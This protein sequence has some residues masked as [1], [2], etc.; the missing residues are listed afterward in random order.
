[1]PADHHRTF[2]QASPSDAGSAYVVK[3]RKRSELPH[4]PRRS[5]RWRTTQCRSQLPL[6]NKSKTQRAIFSR[7]VSS[8]AIM[9]FNPYALEQLFK[10]YGRIDRLT[11]DAVQSARKEGLRSLRRGCTQMLSAE[12]KKFDLK[13][14]ELILAVRQ[15]QNFGKSPFY[16]LT[17]TNFA[18][19]R[20]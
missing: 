16:K 4:A 19:F 6:W 1:M 14:S 18:L 15:S 5:I 17:S 7:V 20:K 13:L 8:F 12:E 11:D 10:R 3:S 9:R 2:T